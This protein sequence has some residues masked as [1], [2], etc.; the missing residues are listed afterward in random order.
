MLVSKKS[1]Q[2][3]RFANIVFVVLFLAA[4]GLLQWLS[5]DYH[6]EFDWTQNNRHSLS[7]ASLAILNTLDKPITIH[8][9]ASVRAG[10]R[11]EI[12]DLIDR[13]RRYKPNIELEFID[14]DKEPEK[15]RQNNIQ[16]DGEILLR[17]GDARET[18]TE[19]TEES[20][21][22]ALTRLGHRGERWLV[23]LGGHGERSPDSQRNFDVSTW[24]NQLSK[25]GFNTRVL[26][27]A[28]TPQIPQNTTALVIASPR[29]NLLEG[30]VNTIMEFAEAGGNILWL[31]DPGGLHGLEPLAEFLGIEFYKGTIID[32]LSQTLTGSASLILVANYNNHDIVKSFRNMTMFPNAAG[33]QFNESADWKHAVFLDTRESAWIET[34]KL[35]GDIAFEKGK[36]IAGPI[37]LGLTLTR[38]IESKAEQRVVVVG[39]GDFLSDTFVGNGGNIDLGLSIMNWVSRDDDYVSIPVRTAVDQGLNL[40][41]TAQ[42]SIVGIFLLGLPITLIAAGV[43]IWLKR[44]KR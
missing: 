33:L 22:N 9:Y 18:I 2:Q 19:I 27:L 39:D 24:A 5:R 32:P 13:Y 31:A 35:E 15:V 3:L 21:T 34:G 12:S 16:I 40:S 14:P 30:E 38:E 43:F 25:R 23:F 29:T 36:D 7:E 44:R 6:L 28:E 42:A 17:Y 11:K 10:Q 41:S 20:L 4:I 8:A 1:R 26:Q 37:N